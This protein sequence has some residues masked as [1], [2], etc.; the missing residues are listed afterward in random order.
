MLLPSVL[1][2]N[3]PY[4]G[5]KLA[6][7]CV[8][9]G[10][11]EDADLGTAVTNLRTTLGLPATL[12]EMGVPQTLIDPVSHAAVIDHSNAS[13]P[14]TLKSSEYAEIMRMAF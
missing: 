3:K 2:F 1:D 9:I 11:D 7:L 10:L 13:N 4:C 12:S 5:E 14:K 6:D 8:A